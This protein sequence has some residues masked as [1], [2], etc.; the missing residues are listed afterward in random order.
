MLESEKKLLNQEQT[1]DLPCSS[2]QLLNVFG[3]TR[4]ILYDV[5]TS[6]SA[7]SRRSDLVNWTLS[8][9]AFIR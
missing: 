7:F 6:Q 2:S 8:R 3:T 1:D 9:P 5:M 4:I